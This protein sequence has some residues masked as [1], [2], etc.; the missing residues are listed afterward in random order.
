MTKAHRLGVGDFCWF[1]FVP[2]KHSSKSDWTWPK[3]GFGSAGI[4]LN[5]HAATSIYSTFDYGFWKPN[6]IDMEL[7]RWAT[8][9]HPPQSLL[10]LAACGELRSTPERV[11]RE[12]GRFSEI[13]VGFVLDDARDSPE[14]RPGWPG[15]SILAF[16]K[17]RLGGEGGSGSAGRVRGRVVALAHVLV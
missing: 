3:L 17:E 11:L 13:N 4:M 14:R 15:E 9:V 16:C 10:A 5:K 2:D 8:T 7:K 6:H 1:S 12:P